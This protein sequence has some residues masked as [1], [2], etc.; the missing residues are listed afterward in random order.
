MRVAIVGYG[1]MGRNIERILEERGH[2]VQVRIDPVAADADA[3]E[4]NAALLEDCDGA[5]EF[6]IAAAVLDNARLYADNKVNA[7]VGTTGW[8]KDISAVESLFSTGPTAYLWGANFSLGAHMFFKIVSQAAAY[9]NSAPEYDIMG[10]EIHHGKKKDS[11]S[12]TAL[13]TAEKIL[14]AN[15]R[16]TTLIQ[17]KLDRHIQE[18]ELHFASLRGGSVPGVHTVLLDSPADTIEIK[19]SARNRD[20]FALGAVMALEWIKDKHGFYSVDNFIDAMF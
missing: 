1:R 11:P 4:L 20:G 2:T 15:K 19:H 18:H 17:D 13:R 3:R 9:L 7:V 14:A 16:K 6:S 10:Y 12:G 5:I 8:D